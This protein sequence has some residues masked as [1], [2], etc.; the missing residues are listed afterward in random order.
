MGVNLIGKEEGLCEQLKAFGGKCSKRKLAEAFQGTDFGDSR[1]QTREEA[2][3][4]AADHIVAGAIMWSSKAGEQG[5]APAAA[6]L[7]SLYAEGRAGV[8]Q[9]DERAVM[10]LEVALATFPPDAEGREEVVTLRDQLAD[11]MD[12]NLVEGLQNRSH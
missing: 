1:R 4:R 5:H 2:M 12:P 10:W 7:G 6:Q 8:R 11:N 3:A 9:N